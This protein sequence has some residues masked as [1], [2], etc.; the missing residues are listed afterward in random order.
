MNHLA[1]SAGRSLDQ[2]PQL[3]QHVVGRFHQLR[4]VAE[5][6]V[7]AGDVRLSTWPGTANTSRPCSMACRA[8]IRRRSLGR[9]RPRSRPA[10]GR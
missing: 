10:T 3:F 4:P 1:L 8:V 5:Q 2:G 9:P 7:A 6:L